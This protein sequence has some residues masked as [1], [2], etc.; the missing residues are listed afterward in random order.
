[1][2]EINL[3]DDDDVYTLTSL[4]TPARQQQGPYKGPYGV[5]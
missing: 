1:M 5:T 3:D 2:S 4:M